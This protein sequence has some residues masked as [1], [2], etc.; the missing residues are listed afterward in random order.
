VANYTTKLKAA[1]LCGKKET[2]IRQEWLDWIDAKIDE[3]AGCSYKGATR[4]STDR[5]D[6]NELIR[7]PSRA[8]SI[9]SITED[10]VV[11]DPT[12][13][14]LETNSRYVSRKRNSVTGLMY[15]FGTQGRWYPGAKYVTTYTEPNGVPADKLQQYDLTAAEAVAQVAMWADKQADFGVALTVS[16]AGTASKTSSAEANSFPASMLEEVDRTIKR[17]IRRS[18]V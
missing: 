1:N 18:G 8:A 4:T 12:E 13:Y 15:G 9:T 16:D 14:E 7:L 11:L 5:G 3:W 2:D 6:G 10:G 17:G